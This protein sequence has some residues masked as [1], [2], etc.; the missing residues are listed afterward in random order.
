MKATLENNCL[1]FDGNKYPLDQHIDLSN[2]D[3]SE[4][5]RGLMVC[6]DLDVSNTKIEE[7]PEFFAISGSLDVS[8][9]PLTKLPRFFQVEKNVFIGGTQIN[10]VPGNACIG[11]KIF[12]RG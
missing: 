3:L 12:W 9:T 4:L 1:V 11:G 8:N 10:N 7:L 2:T 6:G 5:P